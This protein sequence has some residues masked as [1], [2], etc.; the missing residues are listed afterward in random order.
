MNKIY[1]SNNTFFCYDQALKTI[2]ILV[3]DDNNYYF[4]PFITLKKCSEF[5]NIYYFSNSIYIQT[6]DSKL[7]YVTNYFSKKKSENSIFDYVQISHKS[8]ETD[9]ENFD[10]EQLIDENVSN[11]FFVEKNGNLFYQKNNNI[12]FISITQK[13]Q[14]LL[15]INFNIEVLECNNYYKYLISFPFEINDIRFLDNVIEFKSNNTNNFIIPSIKP[16]W[17]YYE[18]SLEDIEYKY[19]YNKFL[20][21]IFLETKDKIYAISTGSKLIEQDFNDIVVNDNIFIIKRDDDIIIFHSVFEPSVLNISFTKY[22][23]NIIYDYVIVNISDNED[24]MF[25]HSFFKMNSK[26]FLNIAKM[27]EYY[28]NENIIIAVS[29]ENKVYYF[30]TRSNIKLFAE[31]N[32]DENFIKIVEDSIIF[33]KNNEYYALF[34]E[35]DTFVKGVKIDKRLVHSEKIYDTDEYDYHYDFIIDIA[36]NKLDQALKL[37]SFF[38]SHEHIK[39]SVSYTC[40][41]KII[42]HGDGVRRDFFDEISKQLL[43]KYFIAEGNFTRFNREQIDKLTDNQ[44]NNLGYLFNLI[45][46]NNGKFNFHF[47]LNFLETITDK[48]INGYE[49]EYFIQ[50]REPDIYKHLLN[51][52]NHPDQINEYGYQS[53]EE[54]LKSLCRYEELNNNDDVIYYICNGFTDF[55]DSEYFKINICT[56][57][58]LLSDTKPANRQLFIEKL[59]IEE[60]DGVNKSI[61]ESNFR[62]FIV[63]LTE[64]EFRVL[65]KNWSGSSTIIDKEYLVCFAKDSKQDINF[66]ACTNT[67]QIDIRMLNDYN[68]L[69]DIIKTPF[70]TM[71]DI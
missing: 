6:K 22:I 47:P 19:L 23:V 70:T 3:K 28:S 44:A 4:D 67:L 40:I 13:P 15:D 2:W 32:T 11:C 25:N 31:L 58:Y 46:Y 17:I 71:I 55:C 41:R 29:N 8:S 64:L 45:L 33:E 7:Y 35:N 54:C 43:D 30:F 60:F 49:M 27:K 37:S 21:V 48:K 39:L 16:R 5:E 24:E 9:S 52:K 36:K 20:P 63:D 1:Y 34:L 56:T 12:Y 61:F 51:I 57:D 62:N 69:F 53:Y 10:N 14:D 59:E 65:L 68:V 26:Y 66:Y 50:E 42:S 18:N 38:P